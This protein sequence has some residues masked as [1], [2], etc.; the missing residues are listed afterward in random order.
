MA[1]NTQ[2]FGIR[3]ANQPRMV[4]EIGVVDNLRLENQLTEL[5]SLVRQLVVGQPQPVVARVWRICTSLEHPTDMCPTLQETKSDYLESVGAIV[6]KA[7][8][9]A[10]AEF[11][12]IC[13]STIRTYP[14]CTSRTNRL[15]TTDS[16]ILGATIPAIAT[17][18]NVS[19]RQFTLYGG[20][21]EAISNKHF[22][23]SANH[24]L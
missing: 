5:T 3:G 16:I 13:S 18:E 23:V 4:N 21:D 17:I 19:S 9:S 15:L 24:E 12:A 8:I 1:S 20:L 22:G 10:R 11:R 2:Q 14:G 7:A 6:W